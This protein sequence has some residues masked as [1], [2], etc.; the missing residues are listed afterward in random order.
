MLE[1]Q[2]AEKFLESLGWVKLYKID[3][4]PQ[5]WYHEKLDRK[6]KHDLIHLTTEQA[7]EFEFERMN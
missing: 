5:L 6:P 4:E 2:N 3:D 7:I 1:I